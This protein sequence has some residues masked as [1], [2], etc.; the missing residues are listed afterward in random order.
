MYFTFFHHTVCTGIQQ[1]RPVSA[2]ALSTLTQSG[3]IRTAVPRA[4]TITV[5]R[6]KSPLQQGAVRIIQQ[7]TGASGATQVI[8]LGSGA[9]IM[10]GT[11]TITVSYLPSRCFCH[12]FRFFRVDIQE[13]IFFVLHIGHPYSLLHNTYCT[14]YPMIGCLGFTKIWLNT[15]RVTLIGF[16]PLLLNRPRQDKVVR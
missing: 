8:N 14:T 5:Q 9:N 2:S 6:Q 4:G 15:L 3:A 11:K 1:V 7:G 10:S 12:H 16:F 13:L